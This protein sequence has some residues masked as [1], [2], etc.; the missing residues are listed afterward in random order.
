MKRHK[1]SYFVK[2]N[3]CKDCYELVMIHRKR[4]PKSPIRRIMW[5][6]YN[7]KWVSALDKQDKQYE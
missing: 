4:K 2:S 7:Y 3:R 5:R 1:T 6:A